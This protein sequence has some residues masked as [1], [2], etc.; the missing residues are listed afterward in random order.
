MNFSSGSEG[1]SDVFFGL[2]TIF[3]THV[4]PAP[5]IKGALCQ[6]SCILACWAV[7]R[8]QLMR[9]QTTVNSIKVSNSVSSCPTHMTSLSALLSK[10]PIFVRLLS[11]SYTRFT[12]RSVLRLPDYWA[13]RKICVYFKKTTVK[14]KS[15]LSQKC[16][17][18]KTN[19]YI[20]NQTA[21]IIQK[22]ASRPS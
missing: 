22:R 3:N 2:A 18:V 17:E 12:R 7:Q 1:V 11:P 13:T 20:R 15:L 5:P 10:W 6:F 4:R 19:K 21:G 14:Q 16:L 9:L 8:L